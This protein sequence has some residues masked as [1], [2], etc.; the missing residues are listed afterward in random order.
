MFT[1][2]QTHQKNQFSNYKQP[3]P[4]TVV[5]QPPKS[6]G[7]L[8]SAEEIRANK[9]RQNS[10][11]APFFSPDSFVSFMSQESTCSVLTTVPVEGKKRLQRSYIFCRSKEH[12][13]WEKCKVAGKASKLNATVVQE[14]QTGH[15]CFIHCLGKLNHFVE[16]AVT[17]PIDPIYEKNPRH[18][19]HIVVNK[20]IQV[21]VTSGLPSSNPSYISFKR[22]IQ[23]QLLGKDAVEMDE[24]TNQHFHL[25]GVIDWIT[26]FGNK[27]KI[28]RRV[29]H[30]LK[31]LRG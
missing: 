5:Q 30:R 2:Q 8:K 7:R 20:I 9:S 11:N 18:C 6:I 26:E 15:R 16:E 17:A 1:S 13:S 3:L 31:R 27:L 19:M 22:I 4:C 14:S 29:F 28:T 21:P 12:S 23:L 25:Q 10:S 24:Y